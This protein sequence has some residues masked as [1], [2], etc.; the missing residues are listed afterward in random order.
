MNGRPE[1]AEVSGV[2]SLCWM[3]P[4]LSALLHLSFALGC[5]G[6]LGFRPSVWSVSFPS[7]I[8][9]AVLEYLHSFSEVLRGFDI[10]ELLEETYVRG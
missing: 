5:R 3:I 7:E 9:L 4:G 1:L 8:T 6:P 2:A 10:I